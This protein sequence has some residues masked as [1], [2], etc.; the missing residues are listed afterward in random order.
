MDTNYYLSKE[1]WTSPKLHQCISTDYL[2]LAAL[3][4]LPK[5]AVIFR[6]SGTSGVKK[7]IVHTRETLLASAKRVNEHLEASDDDVFGL[8]LPLDH[9]GGFGI[10]SRAFLLG[11]SVE[12]YE[13]KWNPHEAYAFLK[14]K[15]VSIT[16]F[17]PTQIYDLVQNKLIA[18]ESLRAIVVGGGTLSV[19]LGERARKL[20]WPVL[21]SYG[22]TEAGSQIATSSLDFSLPYKNT[23]LTILSGWQMKLNERAQLSIKGESLCK[24]IIF[25]KNQQFEYQEVID[26][27]LTNDCVSISAG[28]LTFL[29]RVD[30]TIKVKGELVNLD[31]LENVLNSTLEGEFAV[32]PIE[33]ERAGK[34]LNIY[35]TDESSILKIDGLLPAFVEVGKKVILTE[36]PKTGLG[37]TDYFSLV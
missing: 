2:D 33:H 29:G 15:K 7:W 21:A 28:Q 14:Q 10:L 34:Q 30:R 36:I 11:A 16:S 1:F 20:G 24:G 6:S 19:E 27:Y 9:V 25:Q 3:P 37:K 18:P 17:V 31:E 12:R 22:M 5:G 4:E 23:S 26:Y 35:T 32:K 8:L 13:Q